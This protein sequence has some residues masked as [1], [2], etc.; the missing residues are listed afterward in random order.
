MGVI[1]SYWLGQRGQA[2]ALSS[3]ADERGCREGRSLAGLV[4]VDYHV[5]D[6]AGRPWRHIGGELFPFTAGN[7]ISRA[8]NHTLV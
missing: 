4:V 3:L 1:L 6:W 5:S 8:P 7:A 2:S